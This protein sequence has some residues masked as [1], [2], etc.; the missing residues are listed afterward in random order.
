M[1]D[2]EYRIGQR[3]TTS[4]LPEY[5]TRRPASAD[6]KARRQGPVVEVSG[7]CFDDT[8]CKRI[9]GIPFIQK[10]HKNRYTTNKNAY[11]KPSSKYRLI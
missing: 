5:E 6:R 1:D 2:Y 8:Q 10:S 9:R 11:F 4:R 3:R 7:I